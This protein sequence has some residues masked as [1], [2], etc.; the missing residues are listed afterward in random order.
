ME[1]KEGKI[2]LAFIL[3]FLLI[4][5]GLAPNIEPADPEVFEYKLLSIYPYVETR[6]NDRGGVLSQTI[7][8]VVSFTDGNTVYQSDTF[9][10]D[11]GDRF[12][13]SE[14]NKYVLTKYRGNVIEAVYLT[15]EMF[16]NLSIKGRI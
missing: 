5:L 16:E 6:T 2:I 4:L 12:Y 3:M 14:E 7:K 8:Y 9:C 13:L 10:P 1:S 11:R 15:E